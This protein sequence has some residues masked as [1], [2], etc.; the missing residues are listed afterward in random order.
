MS[1]SGLRAISDVSFDVRDGEIRAVI[2][3]NGAG[4]TTLFNLI[5]GVFAPQQGRSVSTGC[6]SLGGRRTASRDWGWRAPSSR[7][8]SFAP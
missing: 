7:R 1:F 6:P 4:K 3:P 5:T 2:G 8:S